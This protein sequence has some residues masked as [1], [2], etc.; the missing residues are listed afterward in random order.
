MTNKELQVMKRLFFI[1]FA[2]CSMATYAQDDD[3]GTWLELGAE[4]QFVRPFSVGFDAELRTEDNCTKVDCW[5][6]GV[7][8]GYKVNKY[9][10]LGAGF[11]LL[12]GYSS[13][14]ISKEEYDINQNLIAYRQ[15]PSYWTPRYRFVFEASSSIKLWKRIRISLR[16]R[17]QYT[18]QPTQTIGRTDY[19]LIN[20]QWDAE[21]APDYIT[22]GERHAHILRSRIK[23]E[24]D[25]KRCD[26]SP[27]IS[28]EAHNELNDKMDLRKVR[29]MAGTSY[30]INRHHSVSAAYVL[31]RMCGSETNRDRMHALSVGY[32]YKF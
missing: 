32:N 3:F 25:K 27:F 10:K 24:W 20:N 29:A 11:T 8:A 17:Y 18:L 2:C 15:R 30:K 21:P 16:E 14:K 4:K 1:V 7:N 6:M 12:D 23:V 31:T 26:W 28:A 9:L 5:S 13:E 19:E 22:K